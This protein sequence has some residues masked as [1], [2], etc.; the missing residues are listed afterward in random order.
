MKN[1]IIPNTKMMKAQITW[2]F[3]IT[4][5]L[6]GVNSVQGQNLEGKDS[7]YKVVINHEEQYSIL[8]VK[9]ENPEGWKDTKIRGNQRKCQQYIEEVWTDMRPL[10]I[11]EMNLPTKTR[12][13]VVINHEEQYSIWPQNLDVPKT[14]KALKVQG[15]LKKCNAYIEEVWTDMRP[16]SV[17]KRLK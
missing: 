9:M 12:Y 2:L 11:R 10:S 5:I 7:A 1:K 8:P 14:W 16:L 6:I 4:F 17:R 13:M 15:D 3:S